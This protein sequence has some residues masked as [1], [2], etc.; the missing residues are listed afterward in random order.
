MDS[1]WSETCL[2]A[3]YREGNIPIGWDRYWLLPLILAEWFGFDIRREVA[4]K[5]DT[6]P[7]DFI[8]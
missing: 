2:A 1:K 7:L 3:G 6:N 8:H 5:V 4:K